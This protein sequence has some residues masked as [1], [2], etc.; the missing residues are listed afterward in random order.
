MSKAATAAGCLLLAGILSACITV[1]IYFPAPEVRLAAEQIVDETWGEQAWHAAEH[2][3][4]AAR[5]YVVARA[6]GAGP[7]RRTRS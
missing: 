2:A 7:S 6:G 3:E 4:P 1:N 5:W